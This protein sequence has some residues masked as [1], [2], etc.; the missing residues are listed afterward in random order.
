MARWLLLIVILIFQAFSPAS[1]WCEE[2]PVHFAIAAS[3]P[4]LSGRIA[5]GDTLYVK[6]AYKSVGPVRF[7]MEAFAAGKK[8]T[9]GVMYNPAP[10][11]PPGEG[12]ALVWIAYRQPTTVD[13]IKITAAGDRWQS[14]AML[15]A[16][17][18]LEWSAAAAKH[19]RAEWVS[20][21]GR[22]QQDNT[23]RR[24]RQSND[25]NWLSPLIIP[26]GWVSVLGY[27]LLQ[28]WMIHRFAGG[29]R[30]AAILPLVAVVPLF[31]HALLALSAGSNLWPLG[32]IFLMPFA[33]V[34]LVMLAGIKWWAR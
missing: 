34:Y 11:Y 17:V 18:D 33:F 10:L 31:A 26:F 3:D 28:P 25:A 9:A 32:L 19:A 4:F 27:L 30:T 22:A 12:E 2:Q 29:W 21:L 23:G 1:A 6:L 20:R 5:L 8:I 7:R 24:M 13:E 15:R 16:P 14:M